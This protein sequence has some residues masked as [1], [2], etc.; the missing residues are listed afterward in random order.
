MKNERKHVFLS[1]VFLAVG[2]SL[3]LGCPDALATFETPIDGIVTVMQNSVVK[4]SVVD[5][6]GGEGRSIHNVA[7]F[8]S[9]QS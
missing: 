1:K 9:Y 3:I 8:Q 6:N 4:G 5:A 7:V 2:I